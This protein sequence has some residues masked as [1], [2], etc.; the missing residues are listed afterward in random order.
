[1]KLFCGS[2]ISEPTNDTLYQFE[3]GKKAHTTKFNP[4]QFENNTNLNLNKNKIIKFPLRHQQMNFN[5][6]FTENNEV[7]KDH[8]K[9]SK[10][11]S[12]LEIIEYPINEIKSNDNKNNFIKNEDIKDVI[13]NNCKNNIINFLK[14]KPGFTHLNLLFENDD[15][16]IESISE[17]K[18]NVKDD[19]SKSDEIICSYVEIDNDNSVQNRKTNKKNIIKNSSKIFSQIHKTTNS[20]FSIG[21]KSNNNSC[22]NRKAKKNIKMNSKAKIEKIENKINNFKKITKTTKNMII[23][24]LMT[25]KKIIQPK[26]SFK[27]NIIKKH[28]SKKTFK[29]K[30]SQ[31]QKRNFLENLK[32]FNSFRTIAHLRNTSSKNKSL[33]K[34]KSNNNPRKSNK[35]NTQIVRHYFKI[36]KTITENRI[37]NNEKYDNERIFKTT[38]KEPNIKSTKKIQGTKLMRRNA[39]TLVK[40]IEVLK[41]KNLKKSNFLTFK[42]DFLHS[43]RQSIN[44]KIIDSKGKLRKLLLNKNIKTKFDISLNNIN[45][46]SNNMNLLIKKEKN[47]TTNKLMNKSEANKEINNPKKIKSHNKNN[48]NMKEILIR[49][50]ISNKFK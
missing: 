27:V 29:N 38:I 10:D 30:D 35:L 28:N 21:L 9:L 11:V 20:N 12:E 5:S 39:N 47:K 23:D 36:N 44:E 13:N 26:E 25:S 17:S 8:K 2:D 45:S 50:S 40:S 1:M 22:N 42:K 48:K 32:A 33:I 4:Y 37:N 3:E 49:N 14:N 16:S 46:I 19:S 41:S 43:K 18:Y 15:S 31:C 34:E 7:N 6:N 24:K